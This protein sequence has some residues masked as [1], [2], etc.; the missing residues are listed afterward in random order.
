MLVFSWWGTNSSFV[1]IRPC[2]RDEVG[3]DALASAF[4][5]TWRSLQWWLVFPFFDTVLKVNGV[6]VSVCQFVYT[7]FR[8]KHWLDFVVLGMGNPHQKFSRKFNLIN[9]FL[10]LCSHLGACSHFWSIRLISQ[11]LDHSQTVGLLGRVISP[12]QGLYLNTEKRTHT[13]QTSMPWV[14]FEPTIPASERAKTVHTSDRPATVTGKF[15][16]YR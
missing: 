4:W 8:R 3:G 7:F 16:S 13:H 2:G 14:G 11:F 9:C 10:P 1:L 6:T 5:Q 15:K 12:S